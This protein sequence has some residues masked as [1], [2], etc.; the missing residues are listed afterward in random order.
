MKSTK[1]LILGQRIAQAYFDS[2]PNGWPAPIAR[3]EIPELA[4]LIDNQLKG[5]DVLSI[6]R[7]VGSV[8]GSKLAKAHERV[9]EALQESGESENTGELIAA[10]TALCLELNSLQVRAKRALKGN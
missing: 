5:A 6:L 2:T 10:A 7:A 9:S 8:S 3:D 1:R 4:K